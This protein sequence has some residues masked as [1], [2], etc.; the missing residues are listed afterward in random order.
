MKPDA[1]GENPPALVASYHG[2]KKGVIRGKISL[3]RKAGSHEPVR[4]NSS[5][6]FSGFMASEF[7]RPVSALLSLCASA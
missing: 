3:S 2:E 1:I 7:S 6:L 4:V 5:F